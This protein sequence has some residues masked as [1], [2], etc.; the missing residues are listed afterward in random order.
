MYFNTVEFGKRVKETRKT[1]RL[2]QEQ[3]ADIL[4]VDRAHLG[5]I[6]IGKST[7]SIDLLVELSEAL[8]VS[9][10]YLLKGKP[11]RID[12]QKEELLNKIRNLESLVE[13]L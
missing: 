11:Q 7:C 2:T 4:G 13:L 12:S 1:Q 5:R 6:E 9:V 8:H 3:L 10:D